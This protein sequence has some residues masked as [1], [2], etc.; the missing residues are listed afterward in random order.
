MGNSVVIVFYNKT[1]LEV[2]K[3]LKKLYI[4][5]DKYFN[6]L[7]FYVGIGKHTNDLNSPNYFVN[8]HPN[9]RQKNLQIG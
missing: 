3:V 4:G 1:D 5:I 9:P 2:D 7:K 6:K 8:H